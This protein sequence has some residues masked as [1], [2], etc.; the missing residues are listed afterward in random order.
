[1]TELRLGVDLGGTK[2]EG[3]VLG[4][5]HTPLWRERL[6]TESAG[7]YEHILG[8]I[9][10]LVAKMRREAPACRAIGFGTPGSISRR[11]GTLKNS[12]T[13]CLNGRHLRED[14]ERRLGLEVRIEND[15]NC[16][17]LAEN[18]AGAGRGK[19]LMFGVILGTGVGGGIVFDGK[20][21]AGP[22][23]LGGEWG[24]HRI[25]PRG[26]ECYCGKRGCVE[27]F[28]SGPALEK[29][30]R[31]ATQVSLPLADIVARKRAG[32][33]AATAVF[34]RFLDNYGR[35]IANLLTILD[36]EVVVLGGGVSNIDELYTDG[37]AAVARWI[38]NDELTTP[39]RRNQ[40]GD[41]AGVIGAAL[42]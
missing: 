9:E 2:I 1:M 5:D 13:V 33:A 11:D 35:S 32:E 24:H 25:D 12:N 42:L 19:R 30:Y 31:E 21:W 39:I 36:P 7:G 27:A 14:L 20:I 6:P 26:P 4:A 37:R 15:A 23:H 22:Q 16:F 40:L 8:R 29:Q 10:L 18:L 38:C 34:E 3:V 17:A 28:I 41:S